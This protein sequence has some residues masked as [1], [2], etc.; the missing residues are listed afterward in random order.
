MLIREATEEDWP[1]IW[2]FMRGIIAAGDTYTYDPDTPEEAARALWFVPPPGRAFV[3]VDDDGTVLGTSKVARNQAGGG[4]HV[5]NGSYMVDPARSGR[6][7]GRALGE[8]SL[9]WAR[10]AG[11]RGMQFNAVVATNTRAV[12][13]WQSIGFT[14]IGTVPGGFDHP[15]QGSVDLHLM[16]R[17]L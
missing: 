12:T 8:H 14:V 1:A 5:A 11:F 6:G 15:D 3:A 13:L 7:V 4:S 17:D 9:E 2:A 10:A 16:Y